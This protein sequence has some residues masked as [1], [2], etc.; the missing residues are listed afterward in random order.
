MLA[1]ERG[2]QMA[3]EMQISLLERMHKTTK[4]NCGP[5]SNRTN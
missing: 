5:P 2:A 4:P 3:K 1:P